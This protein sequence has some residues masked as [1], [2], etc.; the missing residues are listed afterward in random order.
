MGEWT[1][2]IEEGAAIYEANLDWI[3]KLANKLERKKES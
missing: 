2:D 3:E 1:E